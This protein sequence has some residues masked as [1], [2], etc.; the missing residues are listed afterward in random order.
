M[1]SKTSTSTPSISTKI[2]YMFTGKAKAHIEAP[3]VVPTISLPSRIPVRRKREASENTDRLFRV[4]RNNPPDRYHVQYY[5]WP[6]SQQPDSTDVP[7]F[8]WDAPEVDIEEIDRAAIAEPRSRVSDKG[9]AHSQHV[10]KPL[11]FSASVDAKRARA[12]S[13]RLQQS[14]V[15]AYE[16]QAA[17]S[18]RTGC[19]GHEKSASDPHALRAPP[20]SPTPAQLQALARRRPNTSSA[21]ASGVLFPSFV[22]DEEEDDFIMLTK[23]DDEL[24]RETRGRARRNK[25]QA[26]LEPQRVA[27]AEE[28]R[29]FTIPG[30]EPEDIIFHLLAALP[31]RNTEP[32]VERVMTEAMRKQ[33][34]RLN[35]FQVYLMPVH[36]HSEVWDGAYDD[37]HTWIGVLYISDTREASP[38]AIPRLPIRDIQLDAHTVGFARDPDE[39]PEY[40]VKFVGN[41]FAELDTGV[42][43][44]PALGIRTHKTWRYFPPETNGAAVG[45][46][47]AVA[48]AMPVPMKLFFGRQSCVLSLCATV[49]FGAYDLAEVYGHSGIVRVIIDHLHSEEMGFVVRK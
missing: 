33:S 41:T 14:V 17:S 34:E 12:D 23:E 18:K 45:G 44:D 5:E 27:V 35:R 21:A 8:L 13:G 6:S 28:P 15:D 32:A 40:S 24:I 11:Q 16:D 30:E 49:Q 10:A 36:L 29:V 47:W 42:G 39:M 43:F 7:S 2:R 9:G 25:A 46:T 20:A 22:S 26:K 31:P 4:S 3:R 19:S 48:F 37:V 38:F 1:T